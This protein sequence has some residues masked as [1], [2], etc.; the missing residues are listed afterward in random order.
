MW[1]PDAPISPEQ[2]QK[3]YWRSRPVQLGNDSS[4]A[5]LSGQITP[6]L[7]LGLCQ[8]D[9]VESRLIEVKE[10]RYSLKFGPFDQESLP[11]NN[12]LMVQSL[13]SHLPM[14][15]DLLTDRFDFIPR[16]RIDDVMA[17][18]ADADMSCG[19]HFD[20]YDVFLIQLRGS[21][22]WQLDEG[23]HTD[24]ELSTQS[25]IRLLDQFKATQHIEQRCGDILY[26]PPGIGHWGL[27]SD[28]CLTLSIGV[29][30]PT[31]HEMISHLADSVGD[32]LDTADT[33]DDQLDADK[34]A[35]SFASTCAI[36]QKMAESLQNPSLT[37]QWYGSYM[38]EL[39]EPELVTPLETEL[40]AKQVLDYL[41]VTNTF[42]CHLATR[43]AF[44][45]I[46]ET[47]LLIFVNG[48]CFE[49]DPSILA[50]LRILEAT[51]QVDAWQIVINERNI[52]VLAFLLNTGAISSRN[53]S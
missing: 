21:K 48:Q 11:V 19:A 41:R 15:A 8:D 7:I 42:H 9:L 16:W 44:Q 31:L 24:V 47:L 2:F 3:D 36:T 38:T 18:Y 1:F 46:N 45:V 6:A 34:S 27:A 33:L 52:E 40:N 30:N 13:E 29:L 49:S 17:S 37:Q 53:S 10:G 23:G 26:I 5:A 50:W 12:M 43:L 28:D 32:I 51:R 22:H 35:I 4:L 20:H 39:R 14:V 25:E